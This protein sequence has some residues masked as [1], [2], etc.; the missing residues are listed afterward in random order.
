MLGDEGSTD[1]ISLFLF[2]DYH[3]LTPQ[4]CIQ[5]FDSFFR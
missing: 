1:S 5:G 4:S 3:R 2:Q